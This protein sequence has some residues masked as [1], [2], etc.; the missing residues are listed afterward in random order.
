MVGAYGR[1]VRL[2]DGTIATMAGE[3]V[4]GGVEAKPFA[5]VF[6]FLGHRSV[7]ARPLESGA[8]AVRRRG[9]VSRAGRRLGGGGGG[10]C[11]ALCRG[12][13]SG[14][15]SSISKWQIGTSP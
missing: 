5:Y 15:L 13:G 2:L 11:V 6:V 12:Q 8:D 9:G 3:W 4:I 10:H 1:A 14:T 7:G